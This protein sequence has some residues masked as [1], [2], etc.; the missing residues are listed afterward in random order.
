LCAGLACMGRRDVP[1]H[2]ARIQRGFRHR[3]L[4]AYCWDKARADQAASPCRRRRWSCHRPIAAGITLLASLTAL[5]FVPP[6]SRCQAT[7]SSR[8][9][10]CRARVRKPGSGAGQFSGGRR[11]LAIRRRRGARPGVR[12]RKG[13]SCGDDHKYWR[14][15]ADGAGDLPFMLR[16]S[17]ARMQ[18]SSSGAGQRRSRR[19]SCR[20]A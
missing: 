5:Y 14:S 13:T 11:A 10:P 1:G 18:F 9:R 15:P 19:G 12:V 17:A 6:C 4:S 2:P 20:P 8:D 3:A 16:A 7:C